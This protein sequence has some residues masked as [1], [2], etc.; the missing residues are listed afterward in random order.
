MCA[1][2]RFARRGAVGLL[3]GGGLYLS[4]LRIENRM[5]LK[6]GGY[7][8]RIGWANVLFSYKH[9]NPPS[10]ATACYICVNLESGPT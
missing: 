8:G 7:L 3:R 4:G 10:I 2:A 6:C 5:L 1:K 9:V